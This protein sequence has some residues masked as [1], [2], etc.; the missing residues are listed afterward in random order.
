MKAHVHCVIVGFSRDD[1]DKNKVIYEESG[2]S[3]TAQNISPYLID[4]PNVWIES[5]K[6]PICEIPEMQK[7][8]IPVDDG[9][10][11][12][13]EK[14]YSTF[15]KEEPKA[16][17]FIRPL[18]GAEEFIKN[19]KR[20]CLWLVDASPADLRKCPKVMKRIQNV[21]EFRL[22][23]SKEA[24]RKYADF[25][26]RFMEIRQ[27]D[28]DY[29]LIPS[30]TSENRKYIPIGYISKDFVTTNANFTVPNTTLYHFGVL[31]S[32]VH[33][34]WMRA[35]CGR[36]KSDYRYSKDIVYNNFPWCTPTDAQK[37]K[38]EQTAQAILD[39]RT[40]YPDASL[41]DLYDETT[42]PTEL[43]K[44][45]QENDR[46]VM[47]AYGYSIKMTENEVVAELFKLY[48]KLAK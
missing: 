10:L 20:Y 26:T 39:A 12:I 44:A 46:T 3:Q 22:K 18:L 25:P 9:N 15:I 34:A 17:P 1:S 16:V 2:I 41:A 27:P 33:M 13:E 38:I 43:R 29:L 28:S 6:K 48:E 40:K 4:A 19:T 24:T 32:S 36:L 45:H 11:I 5:R 7:G 8:S 14:D 47:Q 23:S 37:L 42:M 35:V 21:R 30:T 31:T